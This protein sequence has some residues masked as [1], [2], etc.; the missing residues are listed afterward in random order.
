ME[1]AVTRLYAY[2]AIMNSSEINMEL[3][4]EALKDYL[5]K[6][7]SGKNNIQRIQRIVANHYGIN[8]EDLKSARRHSSITL[9]R[10]VAMYLAR[11]LTDESYP[12][13]GLEFGGRDHS[14]VIHAYEKI[15]KILKSSEE[16]RKVIETLKKEC[17]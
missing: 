2:S 16:L 12:R 11:I 1:G 9:P 15:N 4:I 6:N 17:S 5:I 10:Q 8:F 13:I 7:V 3:V 14:T